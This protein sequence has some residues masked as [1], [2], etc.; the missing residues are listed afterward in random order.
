MTMEAPP[1]EGK[2]LRNVA[3]LA[4]LCAGAATVLYAGRSGNAFEDSVLN[5]KASPPSQENQRFALVRPASP[6]DVSKLLESFRLWD[7]D[8]FPPCNWAPGLHGYE[9][10]LIISFSRQTAETE[11]MGKAVEKLFKDKEGWGCFSGIRLFDAGLSVQ[12]DIYSERIQ[13][14]DPNWVNGPNAQFRKTFKGMEEHGYSVMYL[15]E[16]DSFP[17]VD[18]W[19][20]MLLEEVREKQPFGILGSRYKGRAWTRF[21]H[22]MPPALVDHLNGNSVYN[23]SSPLLNV[24]VNELEEEKNSLY[25]AV[26]YDYRISQILTEATKSIPSKFPFPTLLRGVEETIALPSKMNY[27]QSMW[28]KLGHDGFLAESNVLGNYGAV[29]DR[30]EDIG[31]TPIVHGDQYDPSHFT[32]TENSADGRE[33]HGRALKRIRKGPWKPPGPPPF[34]PPG[35]N[36]PPEWA[37]RPG[38]PPGTPGYFDGRSLALSGRPNEAMAALSNFKNFNDNSDGHGTPVFWHIPK[39]SGTHIKL[40][41]VLCYQVAVAA[42]GI[43]GMENEGEF[44]LGN[45]NP[46]DPYRLINADVTTLEGIENAKTRG[47]AD[48]PLIEALASPQVYEIN[49]LLSR[50]KKGQLFA[51]FRHPVERAVSLFNYLKNA[52][53]EPTYKPEY[54]TWTLLDYVYSDEYEDNWMTR[55]LANKPSGDILDE[56]L[57]A[58][59]EVLRNKFL[60][61]LTSH[62]SESVSRFEQY[63]FWEHHNEKKCSAKVR[64]NQ[65]KFEKETTKPGDKV[66]D[67]LEQINLFD[68]ILY[69]EAEKLF[70]EQGLWFDAP[71]SQS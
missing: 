59:L 21:K 9:V 24:V 4:T 54:K 47:F 53:W 70:V 45:P 69:K 38:G 42:E 26:S 33:Y 65:N 64:T 67:I 8:H 66:W 19:L 12:E 44:K 63:F 17:L 31:T 7:D 51:L 23:L 30:F 49:D 40:S 48:S 43:P 57:E 5:E 3:L 41:M 36:G 20:D 35:N 55:W 34:A 29:K 14:V 25:N 16:A 1:H 50:N 6:K 37:G 11:E 39:A 56:D 60:V 61:G 15:M 28:N 52:Y 13:L 18:G 58:A 46:R 2:L 68:M 32:A 22:K 71:A 27:Y 10:D 62:M